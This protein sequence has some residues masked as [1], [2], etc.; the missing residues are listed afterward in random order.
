MFLHG[1]HDA[2]SRD[3]Y[4]LDRLADE[5]ASRESSNF[6]DEATDNLP[7]LPE[8]VPLS[9]D[10]KYLTAEV[11]NVEEFLLARSHT[12]LPDLRVELRQYL[13]ELK[14][15]LVKLINDDYEAFIS[16]STNLRDEGARLERLRHPLGSLKDKVLESK[17]EL[18]AIQNEIHNKLTKRTK[19]REEKALLHLL[20]KISESVTRL[21]SLL[22]ITSPDQ[23]AKES[24]EISNANFLIYPIHTEDGSDDKFR[25]NRAKHLGRVSAEYTQLLY[26]VRKARAEKCA[27]V[28][29][30]QWRIDRVHSTLS[31]DLDQLFAQTILLLTDLK[32]ETRGTELEKNKWLAD[33]T[34]CLRT[35]DTLGLWRDAEDVIRRE[36]VRTF[37]KKSVY[38]GALTAPHSPIAPHTPFHSSGSGPMTASVTA[39]QIPYT[40]FTAFVPKQTVYQP[41]GSLSG[42]PQAQL[43]DDADDPLARLYNQMLRFVERDISRIMVIAE[44]VTVKSTAEL[45]IGEDLSPTTEDGTSIDSKD[46]QIMANVVWDEFGRSIMTELG[47][48][49]FSVGRPNEFRKHYETTQ[50][51]IRSLELLAPSMQAI[52]AL[53]RHPTYT[54]FERR[55]QLPVYF[56]LR[57]K[58]LVGTLEEMLSVVRLEPISPKDGSFATPQASASWIAISACWSSDIYIPEL[59]HRFWR[60]T[61]QILGRYKAWIDE[62]I[63]LGDALSRERTLT[64]PSRGTTGPTLEPPSAET[65]AADDALLRQYA[66]ALIDIRLMETNTITLWRQVIDMMM[67][68]TSSEEDLQM[69]DALREGI[70]GFTSFIPT[71]SS[72]IVTILTRRC[73]DGLLPVRSIPSQFRAMSNK[74]MP[75]EPSYFVSSILLPVK[76]FFG[77]GVTEG[78]GRL[79]KDGFL[80]SFSTEVFNNVTQRY[81]SYLTAMKKT[82]ESLKRLKKGK[83]STYSLFGNNTGT[84]DEGRDEERIRSQMILDVNAFGRDGESL[85]IE[86]HANPSFLTLKEMVYASDSE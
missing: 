12:S 49:V 23:N 18:Q 21:E 1:N 31:S 76:Q 52:K 63:S 78:A 53:R 45:R 6:Q 69:E 48:V 83:K 10:D 41:V 19:L 79:L 67:P 74:R 22:L 36:L 70:S 11:F 65:V 85:R 44:K 34:E 40:P 86:V 2:S 35:Y 9:H 55:W 51:F 66:A 47:G 73:C 54:A 32:G 60:L 39:H 28:D 82:E 20:L 17:Q 5:L 50:G 16:L 64:T 3:P 46:F 15:E 24:M 72:K 13:A 27:F 71:L 58:E 37:V 77:V 61:L 8:H 7:D 25:G 42:L 68:E 62:N 57:W 75:M 43:L 33:L 59:S 29:E 38:P 14:E 4:R 80:K 81:I 26:H 56:Q 84:S 30:V